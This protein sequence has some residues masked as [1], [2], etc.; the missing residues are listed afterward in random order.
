LLEG[1]VFTPDLIETWLAYKRAKK[2]IPCAVRPHPYEFFLYYDVD[3]GQQR[4]ASVGGAEGPLRLCRFPRPG[5]IIELHGHRPKPPRLKRDLPRGLRKQGISF[6]RF[7]S[8]I[9]GST[10]TWSAEGQFEKALEGRIMF[11]GSSIEGF[12]G[13]R[14][15][16]WC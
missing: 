6:L 8:R 2:S 9:S 7:S 4:A 14:S 3:L 10:R 1:G 15:R 5:F 13:S 12:V 11:D 16:T